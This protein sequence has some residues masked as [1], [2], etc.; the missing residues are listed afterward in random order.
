[1]TVTLKLMQPLAGLVGAKELRV[2]FEGN[3]LADLIEHLGREHGGGVIRELLDEN[4][5]LDH[6][7]AVSIDGTVVRS[8]SAEVREGAEVLIFASIVGGQ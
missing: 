8:L 5:Q 7:Y 2:E 3:T 6:S 1:M 4:G